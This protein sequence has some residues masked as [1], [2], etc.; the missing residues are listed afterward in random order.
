MTVSTVTQIP[1]PVQKGLDSTDPDWKSYT[2]EEFRDYYGKEEGDAWWV[3]SKNDPALSA[4]LDSFD[5][6]TSSLNQDSLNGADS[7]PSTDL[8]LNQDSPAGSSSSSSSSSEDSSTDTGS[9]PD[10]D[11]SSIAAG[12]SSYSYSSSEFSE[13]SFPDA[14]S[15]PVAGLSLDHDEKESIPNHGIV[16]GNPDSIEDSFPLSMSN[17]HDV[18][19]DKVDSNQDLA[20]S[21]RNGSDAQTDTLDKMADFGEAPVV[22]PPATGRGN[23]SNR[24]RLG[25]CLE[26][27]AHCT[28]QEFRSALRQARGY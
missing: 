23:S 6:P 28:H 1:V 26:D 20:S 9:K 19:H 4:D 24:R 18:V 13:Y 27:C 25:G 11:S 2:N 8:G 16:A 5:E 7:G 3:H 22:E 17:D 21:I 15:I 14:G 10:T 12:S